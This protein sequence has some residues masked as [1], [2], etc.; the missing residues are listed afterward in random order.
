MNLDRG[1]FVFVNLNR[2]I[3]W[4][5]PQV[6]L[7]GMEKDPSFRV[8]VKAHCWLAEI[9][10]DSILHSRFSLLRVIR[11]SNGVTRPC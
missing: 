3:V 10:S 5:R 4:V 8:M 11:P 2:D 7:S 1:S 6:D 9:G